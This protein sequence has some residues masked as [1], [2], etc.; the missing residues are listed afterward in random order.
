MSRKTLGLEQRP[1]KY[2]VRRGA[3]GPRVPVKAREEIIK[4]LLDP[5]CAQRIA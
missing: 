5:A 1:R 4:L 3:G 2:V